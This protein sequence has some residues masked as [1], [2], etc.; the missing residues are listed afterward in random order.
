MLSDQ[1]ILQIVLAADSV[2]LHFQ[3]YITNETLYLIIGLS[4]ALFHAIIFII[5]Q[6]IRN[7]LLKMLLNILKLAQIV[8]V[9]QMFYQTW[10]IYVGIQIVCIIKLNQ[11]LTRIMIFT[12]FCIHSAS[13]TFSDMN[14]LATGIV[15]NCLCYILL[16]SLFKKQNYTIDQIEEI[17]K[18][19]SSDIFIF[20]DNNF[21]PE[22]EQENFQ[23]IMNDY[24]FRGGDDRSD[25]IITNRE[26][27]TIT[28]QP[29]LIDEKNTFEF[30]T[31]FNHLKN[32]KDNWQDQIY[33]TQSDY[34]IIVK[35]VFFNQNIRQSNFIKC[36]TTQQDYF[37]IIQKRLKPISLKKQHQED[38]TKENMKILSKVSHDMRTPL[39]AIINMQLC[40]KDQIDETLTQRYLKPSLNSCRLLLNLVNDIL[41]QAQLQNRKIRLVFK[42]FN[43]KKLINKTISIFDIQK[44]KKELTIL[45]N[46]EVNV[47]EFINSDKNRIRQVIMNLLSNA[48][49]YSM[50]KGK[51]V[52]TCEFMIKSQT[53]KISVSDTGLGI[54]PENLE[55]LFQEFARVEDKENLEK[56][57]NGIG[58]GLLISN[59]LSRLLSSN[60]QGISVES[61]YLNGATFS[62]QILNQKVPDED[63]SDSQISDG[64]VQEVSNLP[65]SHF[66]QQYS[67]SFKSKEFTMPIIKQLSLD[68][69]Q[70]IPTNN[71]QSIKKYNLRMNSSNLQSSNRLLP[72]NVECEKSYQRKS[73]SQSNQIIEQINNW[74]DQTSKQPP[75]LIVDDNEFNIIVLQYILE[76][77][78]LTCDSAISGQ[79]ALKKC[80]ERAFSQ[81]KLI[82]LDIEMP[83]M[84]G[85]E[86][87]KK[88]L[89]FDAT[90]KII[91]CT[92]NRQTQ[93]QLETYKQVGMLGAI[94]K[95]VT[96]TNLKE[97]L[98]N[99]NAQRNDAQFT[100]YF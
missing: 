59:E 63:L 6:M 99:L 94:E 48:V 27:N 97:L 44:E 45:F 92:G 36:F 57:P 25:R 10:M 69:Q 22:N 71:N 87:T 75:V 29:K 42:K 52:I 55:M 21:N 41:D 76:Q 64:A 82:F 40:L 14:Y 12:L 51:I 11:K 39:N 80:E 68:S 81:Y 88:L 66:F 90:L 74:L 72:F 53:F 85:L 93:A 2:I 4:S 77:L 67:C 61:Q 32:T 18:Q 78:Y 13:L 7:Q 30:K 73:T 49:K 33:E 16:L 31:I 98:L 91:A 15:R 1:Q 56:N 28:I 37:F 24:V 83:E 79:I 35:K 43:L 46:Y 19:L 23:T 20:L 86:T 54:K 5:E 50:A 9:S 89:E 58:L 3:F 38:N 62:F 17:I 65:E 34:F 95:P 8:I 47:P 96:K 84:D 70:A 100:H 26:Q 60:N